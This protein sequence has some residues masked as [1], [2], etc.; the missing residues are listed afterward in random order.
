MRMK[1]L[2]PLMKVLSTLAVLCVP[3]L[4]LG[5]SDVGDLAKKSQ[6]PVDDIV[7]LPFQNNTG[8]GIGPNDSISN[9][10]NLQPVYPLGLGKK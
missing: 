5:Q 7:S 2:R 8:F 9:V 4:V 3:R 1:R 10:L 6:N